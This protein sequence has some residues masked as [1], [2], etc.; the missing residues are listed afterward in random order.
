MLEVMVC[1]PILTGLLELISK[2]GHEIFEAGIKSA[3]KMLLSS[4]GLFWFEK[5]CVA[6]QIKVGFVVEYFQWTL[7]FF[8]IFSVPVLFKVNQRFQVIHLIF[9]RILNLNPQS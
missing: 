5:A 7:G 3:V 6:G 2:A 8:I 9:R 4:D 1:P